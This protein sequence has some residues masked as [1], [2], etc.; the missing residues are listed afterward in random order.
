[1]SPK[2]QK[3][4]NSLYRINHLLLADD[5]AGLS[6]ARFL[7]RNG[8]IAPRKSRS[9]KLQF[10][11]NGIPI[12]DVNRDA[13]DV[14]SVAFSRQMVVSKKVISSRVVSLLNRKDGI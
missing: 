4:N 12:I 11:W 2:N 1:M 14:L 8:Q 3:Q 10:F 9:K 7:S 13:P 6:F 5:S